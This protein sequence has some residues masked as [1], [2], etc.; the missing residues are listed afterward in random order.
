MSHLG[1]T[2]PLFADGFFSTCNIESLCKMWYHVYLNLFLWC[3][4]AK[5]KGACPHTL[6][7]FGMST[8]PNRDAGCGCADSYKK[9]IS[10]AAA[11]NLHY[12]TPGI[13]FVVLRSIWKGPPLTQLYSHCV[14]RSL[15]G[16]CLLKNEKLR[17]GT[18]FLY[19]I[20]Q[21]K[22]TQRRKKVKFLESAVL[23]ILS[24]PKAF[25]VF[26]G[27]LPPE[28]TESTSCKRYNMVH[29]FFARRQNEFCIFR[30]IDLWILYTNLIHAQTLFPT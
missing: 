27:M 10:S 18:N 24:A 21:E 6:H 11:T 7:R 5:L 20:T 8:L 9:V 22:A 29:Y 19:S 28:A 12:N 26:R 16:V 2:P 1:A 30:S 4:H 17:M 3:W 23:L 13:S 25:L 15:G 14:S